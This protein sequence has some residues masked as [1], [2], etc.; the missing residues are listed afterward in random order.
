MEK[1]RVVSKEELDQLLNSHFMENGSGRGAKTL[2]LSN[3]IISKYVFKGDLS[4]I[5]FDRSELR[6][7]EFRM[8]KAEH[9]SFQN[10]ALADCK[11]T[12]SEFEHCNF[13][14]A[15]I[16]G[17]VIRNSMFREGSFDAAY[18]RLSPIDNSIFYRTSFA[19]TRIREFAGSENIFHECGHPEN[20]V[21]PDAGA[22]TREESVSYA[23]SLREAFSNEGYIY[24][25]ELNR[26]DPKNY[27]ADLS[28][29][30][31][32]DGE[33]VEEE[34]YSA[35]LDP[36]TYAISHIDTRR[37]GDSLIRM[38][39]PEMNT[40]IMESLQERIKEQ[41]QQRV[42]LKFPYMTR[43]TF[44]AVKDEIKHMGAE[45]DPNRKEW[46]VDRSVGKE[47]ITNIQDYITSHDEAIYL[48]LPQSNAKEFR[49][50]IE[51]LKKDGARYNPDKKRWYI[52]ES[53][54]RTKFWTYLPTSAMIFKQE[55]SVHEKL[56]QYRQD[57]KQQS[58]SESKEKD[59]RKRETPEIG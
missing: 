41:E 4:A 55:N 5:S 11:L 28:I 44:M 29:K 38:F 49:S 22:M 46:Y 52:T 15:D 31:S 43:D 42:R 19:D 54:D 57:V 53:V 8:T 58:N 26:V 16:N 2:D 6:Y 39:M 21:R 32:H 27:A 18:M 35:L 30:I 51:Q 17:T 36:D 48:K 45:F 12:Q 14:S 23:D 50:M 1:K 9:V 3:C 37:Q 34:K 47:T 33:I 25:W 13:N 7:C 24:S 56:N 10:A 59:G 20:T 40:V